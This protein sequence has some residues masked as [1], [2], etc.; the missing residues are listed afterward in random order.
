MR[1]AMEEK[2]DMIPE[3][4]AEARESIQKM[5]DERFPL[6][7]LQ[8]LTAAHK[9]IV[10]A[11]SQIFPSSSSAD[12]ILPTLIY[13]LITSPPDGICVISNLHFVQRF[14]TAS[15]VD[16]EAAYC[17]VNLEASIAF[18]ENV[19]LSTLRADELPGGPGKSGRPVTPRG[20]APPMDLGITPA[21]AS[22]SPEGAADG[23]NENLPSPLDKSQRRLS[24]LIQTQTNRIEAASDAARQAVLDSADQAFES[25]NSTLDNSLKFLFGRLKEQQAGGKNDPVHP[26]TLEDVRK[27]V[28]TPPPIDDNASGSSSIHEETPDARTESKVT[29]LFG[30]R[31]QPPLREH[32]VDSAKS[33][34]S[35]SSKRL[36]AF[37]TP[38]DKGTDPL[39]SPPP[40]P[41]S[42]SA[43]PPTTTATNNNNN[44]NNG[45]GGTSAVESMRSLGNTLNPLRG[46]GGMNMLP[47][48]GRT[49]TAPATPQ[50]EK[51]D[52]SP[53]GEAKSGLAPVAAQSSPSPVLPPSPDPKAAVAVSRLDEL[54]KTAPP[55]KRFIEAKEAKELKIGDVEELL[56]D[57]QRLAGAL[58]AAIKP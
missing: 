9:S 43:P 57:Y 29:D 21:K 56:K 38:A 26:K 37:G 2:E 15:K 5:N 33:G 41:P 45:G 55:V 44:N 52:A 3:M 24:N 46:F 13:T 8:C 51:R 39:T 18:L 42:A 14:R 30:G 40:P 19:D 48:F 47:R 54:S 27:L 53:S 6:G 58:R 23:K 10:E 36:V 7:K 35:G 28:S 16:G 31:R 20:D 12:E 49:N 32:S 17:L 1:K 11:L 4:L 25:I 50:A 34:A 22:L